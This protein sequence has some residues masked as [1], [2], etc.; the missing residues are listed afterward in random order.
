MACIVVPFAVVV[1]A[2][3]AG[4]YKP[5]PRPY[6][7]GLQ[8]LG[9]T[10]ERCLFVAGSALDLFGTARVGL[11]T[12]WHDWIGMAPPPGAPAPL[13]RHNSLTPLAAYVFGS[14]IDAERPFPNSESSPSSPGQR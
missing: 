3:R 5:D 12:W 6:Q 14:K 2:E 9:V 10:A 13:A 4:Y 1:T 8:E 7:L 11:P